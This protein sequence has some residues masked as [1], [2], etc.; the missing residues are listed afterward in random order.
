MAGLTPSMRNPRKMGPY[1]SANSNLDTANDPRTSSTQS[2]V[3]L[4]EEPE[5]RLGRRKLL[6]IYIH[7]F[8]GTETSFQ[9]FPAHVHNLVTILLDDSHIIHTKIYPRY[10]SKGSLLSVAEDLSA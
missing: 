5:S 8:K 7:G 1:L 9:S 3:P 2:L 6:L 10:R 4:N